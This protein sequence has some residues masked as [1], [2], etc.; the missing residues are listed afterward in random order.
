MPSTPGDHWREMSNPQGRPTPPLEGLTQWPAKPDPLPASQQLNIG[1]IGGGVAGLYAALLL[2]REGHLVRIFEG[3]DRVG[4]R[5]YTHYF[6]QEENQYFEAGAMRIPDSKFHAITFD[7]IDYVQSLVPTDRAV[8]LIPYHLNSAGNDLFINGQRKP[9]VSVSSTT[10]AQLDWPDIPEKFN[11]SASTLLTDAISLFI[12]ALENDFAKGIEQL[13][14]FDNYSFRTYLMS[15]MEYP[16]SV[17]DFMETV[18]SQTNQYALSVPELVLESVDFSTKQWY[19]I[20]RG[21]SRLPNAM[22]YLVGYECI[23][24]GAR[25]TGIRDTAKG[26]EVK[27]VGYNG[28]LSAHFDRVIVAIPPAALKMIADR[29]RWPV[30]KEMAIRSM[31][32]EAVYK[33]GLRFKT[34]FWE[35]VGQNGPSEGGQSTTDLPIR[36]LVFPSNGIDTEGPGVLLVYAWMTDAT[37][38]LPLTP[39]ERRSL[40]LYCIAKLYDG[41]VDPESGKSIKVNDLLISSADAIWSSSTATGNAF[42]LPGQFKTRFEPARRPEG[43]VYFAGEHLSYHHTWISGALQSALYTVSLMLDDDTLPPLNSGDGKYPEANRLP[44]KGGLPR[45]GGLPVILG[46]R[47]HM[48]AV[49]K[50]KFSFSPT[51]E[52][53]GGDEGKDNEQAYPLDLG[54]GVASALGPQVMSLRGPQAMERY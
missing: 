11:K 51:F 43:N 29:D 6:T 3:T 42:L 10:P 5:V 48:E 19:T 18:L 4:G 7:L 52:W 20:D 50:I 9:G 38:W 23:T 28:A 47:D 33:M 2:Q 40:A 16:S 37:T 1:I 12:D 17:V 30:D 8:D 54:M 24:Y 49:P 35:R 32:F 45:Q 14:K 31:H 13:L 22:A 27:A 46:P 21:M 44:W 41:L 25:V 53:T 26:V 15:V 34:R 36:W 39:I